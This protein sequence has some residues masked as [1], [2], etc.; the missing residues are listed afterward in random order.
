MIRTCRRVYPLTF[1]PPPLE[2]CRLIHRWSHASHEWCHEWCRSQESLFG[3]GGATVAA[4]DFCDLGGVS[5]L[6]RGRSTRVSIGSARLMM[7]L[8]R[9]IVLY[10]L[11]EEVATKDWWNQKHPMKVFFCQKGIDTR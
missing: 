2:S 4:Q 3:D 7:V 6:W 1:V 11:R 10:W 9:M 8:W 5:P